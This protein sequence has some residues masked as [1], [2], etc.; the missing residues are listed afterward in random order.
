MKPIVRDHEVTSTLANDNQEFLICNSPMAFEILSSSLYTNKPLAIL[1]ELIC[2][3]IDSHTDAGNKDAK[4]KVILPS[5]LHPTL[6]IEDWGTGLSPDQINNLYRIYFGSNRRDSNDFIGGRGLGS[7]SP[8]SYTDQFSVT[9]WHDGTEYLYQAYLNEDHLPSLTPIYS[10]PTDRSNGMRIDIPVQEGDYYTFR[11]NMEAL[12]KTFFDVVDVHG[13]CDIVPY[14]YDSAT[15]IPAS[16]TTPEFTVHMRSRSHS[17]SDRPLIIMGRVCYPVSTDPRLHEFWHNLRGDTHV[18]LPVG[19]VNTAP[20]REALSLDDYSISVMNDIAELLMEVMRRDIM[21][22]DTA[23]SW[24]TFQDWLDNNKDLLRILKLSAAQWRGYPCRVDNSDRIAYLPVYEGAVG[25]CVYVEESYGRGYRWKSRVKIRSEQLEV[26]GFNDP[27]NPFHGKFI[28]PIEG[29]RVTIYVSPKPLHQF[30]YLIE[31]PTDYL[32]EKRVV[33]VLEGDLQEVQDFYTPFDITVEPLPPAPVVHRERNTT[34]TGLSREYSCVTYDVNLRAPNEQYTQIKLKDLKDP[35]NLILF[36][37]SEVNTG[38]SDVLTSYGHHKETIRKMIEYVQVMHPD[39]RRIV[40]VNDVK[41][42]ATQVQS[43]LKKIGGIER[44]EYVAWALQNKTERE[45]TW[46]LDT[47][48]I[49]HSLCMSGNRERRFADLNTL[50]ETA[51]LNRL[52]STMTSMHKSFRRNSGLPLEN[53]TM[54]QTIRYFESI[55]HTLT[56][57]M[58]DPS[59]VGTDPSNPLHPIG[60]SALAGIAHTSSFLTKELYARMISDDYKSH[61][62]QQIASQFDDYN[63]FIRPFYKMYKQIVN[64]NS[65]HA[66]ANIPPE[67]LSQALLAFEEFH[68][69]GVFTHDPE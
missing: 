19:T 68:D 56:H 40:F 4:V 58:Y 59:V 9:S 54:M 35:H 44:R 46:V 57:P 23:L 48:Y 26:I 29:R 64:R 37:N 55:F 24:G 31:Y 1:R 15:V 69:Q 38:A 5:T 3:G 28:T 47:V 10:K 13:S 8:F 32:H 33:L 67:F 34:P 22:T 66:L 27:A 61:I 16:N 41:D 43:Y 65:L 50:W 30:K 60:L 51:G 36:S 17:Y 63:Q 45:I 6:T 20:S 2:N 12:A 21:G 18:V 49:M 52:Y 14:K 7:K 11:T 25:R 53:T 62:D 42:R 39:K